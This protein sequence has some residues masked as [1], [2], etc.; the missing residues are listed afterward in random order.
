MVTRPVFD[1]DYPQNTL[2]SFYGRLNYSLMDRYLLT[3]TVR[4]D[5]SSRFSKE[6]R[7]GV[8]PALALAW[9]LNQESFLKSISWL[10]DLKLRVGYG[11]T[12]QQ[13]G[14]GNY[15]YLPFYSLSTNTAQYLLGDTYYNMLRPA[16][17][18]ADIHWET[19]A[20][21]NIGLDFG[22]L[23]GR[24]SGTLDFYKRKTSDL[25]NTIPVPA[26]ANFSNRILTNIGNIDSKGFELSL[27]ATPIQTK[28][29]S[30]DV[31]YNISSNST[32]ITK[33]NA[34]ELPGYQGVPNGGVAGS[35]DATVQIHSVGYAPGTFFVYEQRYGADGKPLE[36]QFVDRNNDGVLNE[37]DK[38]RIHNPEP[39]VVM[40]LSTSL[41]FDRWTLSTSLRSNLGNYIYDNVSSYMAN[42]NA[43]LNSGQFFRNTTS[44]IN[45]SNFANAGDKQILSDYYLH[46]A[47][48]LKM[49]NLTLAYD[50]GRILGRTSLRASATVQNVFTLSS[51]KGV[52]PERAIDFS[53]Y[54]VPRTYTLNLS[55]SL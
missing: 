18:D 36:G 44:E 24:L 41:T 31:N 28:R 53:L 17:Y 51:Y 11:V 42:H 40:G 20:T 37:Q 22:F 39:K 55:F 10:D 38:Y 50:F 12:G 6:N 25:L 2:V 30:W 52:D 46:R 35:T 29:F 27:N 54:P 16:A 21:S 47:S 3:A 45:A 32:R 43:V 8:F 1:V 26:G 19:T 9:R 7:W 4:T 13:D 33:L 15:T 5:G 34:V 49:D 48:F 23:G 14:I